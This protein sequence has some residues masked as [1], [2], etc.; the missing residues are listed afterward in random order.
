MSGRQ[1]YTET[2][3]SSSHVSIPERDSSYNA[4]TGY[5]P[6]QSQTSIE[7]MSITELFC[8]QGDSEGE[9]TWSC[10]EEYIDTKLKIQGSKA[11]APW[12]RPEDFIPGRRMFTPPVKPRPHLGKF[13][14]HGLFGVD[15]VAFHRPPLKTRLPSPLAR[16]PLVNHFEY[17]RSQL[18]LSF[19][20]L[21]QLPNLSLTS[22][23]LDWDASS[24]ESIHTPREEIIEETTDVRSGRGLTPPET[25][26]SPKRGVVKVLAGL[27]K[28]F[29]KKVKKST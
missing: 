26:E 7:Q 18:Q 16:P 11:C 20:R 5:Q 24:L 19:E 22:L 12:A 1:V 4:L 14:R 8:D 13:R 29:L 9:E 17:T 28:L 21:Q 6:S 23:N 25:T 27:K 3:Y 2:S 15:E 10:F